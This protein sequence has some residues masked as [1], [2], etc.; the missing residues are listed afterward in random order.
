MRLSFLRHHLWSSQS[1]RAHAACYRKIAT[2]TLVLLLSLTLAAQAVPAL[3]TD[4]L[5]SPP[6]APAVAPVISGAYPNDLDGNR[7]D[8]ELDTVHLGKGPSMLLEEDRSLSPLA[9]ARFID[10][11]LIFDE[12]V[13]Q[14]QIDAFARL[15]G[16]ITYMFQSVS[17]GWIGCMAAD[18][19]TLLP[20]AMGP[21]LVLVTP[22]INQICLHMDEATRIGRVRPIW[23]PGFAGRPTG[24][25]GDPN[26]TIAIVDTGVDDLHRDLRDRCVYW[27]D[28][29]GDY[30]PNAVD[31]YGH[32]SLVAGVALGTGDSGGA[33]EGELRYTYSL[34]SMGWLHVAAP[35]ALPA[36]PVTVT[37]SALWDGPSAWLDHVTWP[38]GTVLDSPQ[39]VGIGAEGPG[40]LTT[41]HTFNAVEGQVFAPILADYD[42]SY[43]W[44]VSIVTTVSPYP[45]AG[46]GFNTF[47]GVAPGCKVAGVKF[48]MRNGMS[49]ADGVDTAIDDLVVRRKDK[50][51]KI[52]NV[53]A[54]LVDA[55]GLPVESVTLRDKVTTAVRS[56]VVV[57]LSAG[58]SADEY[59]EEARGMSDPA[60]TALAI[61]VGASNDENAVTEYSTYGFL[62][63]RK[64]TE[65]DFKPDLVAPGGSYYYTGIMS[66]DSGSTDGGL[67][68]DRELDDYAAAQ[69]TSFSSPFVAGCAALV[70]EAIE[71]QGIEWDFNSDRHPRLVKMLLCATASETNARREGGR[72]SPSLQRAAR[73]PDGFPA[74]KDR[75]EGY[76]MINAD[77]AVEAVCLTYTPGDTAGEELGPTV[78][79]RR[80]W[81][82]TV[83]LVAGTGFDVTLDNPTGGDFDL[84]LYSMTPSAS[85][86]PVVLASSTN[87][88][89][90]LGESLQHM[91]D[92]DA[93]VLLVV[94]RVSGSGAF[95]LNSVPTE[96][97]ADESESRPSPPIGRVPQDSRT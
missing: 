5:L 87:P 93:S 45:A 23:Q 86:T 75:H 30:E 64:Y 62:E 65:E 18:Q 88:G 38:K 78:A 17:Y 55:W 41:T 59:S 25:H 7:I 47:S 15:G 56:G 90:G 19:V 14:D 22:K 28:I 73:G 69:G 96:S 36:G 76:G 54:G 92:S 24:F 67:G 35:I 29:S 32:G 60:R 61:T 33:E 72:F 12:P 70:I 85:G 91:S 57:V 21:T 51:I 44:N 48:A 20:S 37:S 50:N 40:K 16:R 63:P 1:R 46:D 6:P 81:A 2:P 74:G 4:K 8:D 34:D 58:N 66:I 68:P 77:A 42:D 71:H 97:P 3:A 52:I 49:F 11:E 10:V 27:N 89:R 53:S 43:L 82:R 39:W 84:Y 95:D 13:T 9:G 83:R 31:Y 26:T 79:D 94:K 80:V